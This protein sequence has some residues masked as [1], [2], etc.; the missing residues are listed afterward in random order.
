[1]RGK[2]NQMKT[3]CG[4]LAESQASRRPIVVTGRWLKTA[5]I[6]DEE[7]IEGQAVEDPEAYLSR[8][9]AEF[10]SAD[11]FSFTQKL[12]D[13]SP[14][15]PYPMEWD[16]M[17]AIPITSY[18]DW[19][20]R[21]SWKRKQEFRKAAKR[22]VEVRRATCD[23]AFF[24]G[25]KGIYDETPVRQGR[26]FWHYGKSLKQV[27]EENS[28]YP[29]RS[30]YI[31]AYFENELIGFIR[32]VYVGKSAVL[33]QIISMIKHRSRCVTNALLAKAVEISAA[34]GMSHLIYAKYICNNRSLMDFKRH[35]GFEQILYPRYFI[36]LTIKGALAL[37]LNLHRGIT[38]A[39]PRFLIGIGFQLRW[40]WW[41]RL[42]TKG[43][44]SS[45][46][47][48]SDNH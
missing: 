5:E 28:T 39:M 33:L 47:S 41:E 43:R 40:F 26:R 13:L 42:S 20:S 25:I 19:W 35:N 23:E 44:K 30:E 27:R 6:F 21:H 14:K 32:M 29:E 8:I 38:N 46:V 18:Q 10:P 36:P 3:N 48:S 9:R 17:A 22:G 7:F 24:Q 16:N 1:M 34:K 2:S 37:R 31:G 12:P 45:A 15:Y 11:L 4:T